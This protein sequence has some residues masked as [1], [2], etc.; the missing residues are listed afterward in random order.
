MFDDAAEDDDPAELPAVTCGGAT[1]PPCSEARICSSR[2]W[3]AIS[4]VDACTSS[5]RPCT[6]FCASS[7]DPIAVA[8]R[9]SILSR[10]SSSDG[11]LPGAASSL[12][13]LSEL[14]PC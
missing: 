5:I 3:P 1:E 8:Y 7:A 14:E 9:F 13:W 4:V 12:I 11:T 6:E 10:T 2:L